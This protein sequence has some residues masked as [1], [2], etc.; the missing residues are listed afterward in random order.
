MF[1]SFWKCCRRKVNSRWRQLKN[2][3]PKLSENLPN[4]V[5]DLVFFSR[6]GALWLQFIVSVCRWVCFWLIILIIFLIMNIEMIAGY[7]LFFE[8]GFTW[9]IPWYSLDSPDCFLLKTEYNFNMLSCTSYFSAVWHYKM[10]QC[11]TWYF[12]CK[13]FYCPMYYTQSI[14]RGRQS[15]REIF[16]VTGPCESSVQISFQ[17]CMRRWFNLY[18]DSTGCKDNLRCLF[19][20]KYHAVSIKPAFC[21]ISC[22]LTMSLQNSQLNM[23]TC[24]SS[25]IRKWKSRNSNMRWEIM[26]INYEKQGSKN[27]P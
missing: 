23:T 26:N 14:N 5:V 7:T 22:F 8:Q 9:S 25:V 21:L 11:I 3:I 27:I 16:D 19:V 15:T 12:S 4:V 13:I 20:V 1:V 24:Q 10:E 6:S 18:V 17:K 2:L